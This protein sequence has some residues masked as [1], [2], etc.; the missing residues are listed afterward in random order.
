MQGFSGFD[1]L[2]HVAFFAGAVDAF[3]PPSPVLMRLSK[4]PSRGLVVCVKIDLGELLRLPECF[5][6]E[7]RCYR[8]GS[9]GTDGRLHHTGGIPPFFSLVGS[10]FGRLVICRRRQ[11]YLTCNKYCNRQNSWILF[12]Q[13]ST[14]SLPFGPG[15]LGRKRPKPLS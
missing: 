10:L 6:S 11:Q 1:A 14:L 13:S 4:I 9:T 12:L 15:S 5:G 7:G 2:A 8:T 3:F